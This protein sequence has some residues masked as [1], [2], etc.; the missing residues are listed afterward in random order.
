MFISY[1]IVQHTEASSERQFHAEIGA[2]EGTLCGR[3]RDPTVC[4]GELFPRRTG[5]E[6]DD[7]GGQNS[8]R[9]RYAM[10]RRGTQADARPNWSP[11]GPDARR[12]RVGEASR[13][14]IAAGG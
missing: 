12:K 10:R 3:R 8:Q 7:R 6:S 2:V 5:E 13:S 9:M 1:P 14:Y 4:I 11:F